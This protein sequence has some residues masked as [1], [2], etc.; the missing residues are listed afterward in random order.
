MQVCLVPQ[1]FHNAIYP[2]LFDNTNV[3]FMFRLMPYYFGAGCC[4]ITG[5]R[6]MRLLPMLLLVTLQRCID[7]QCRLLVVVGSDT[8][9]R[10]RSDHNVDWRAGT[11][12]MLRARACF[13]ACKFGE[14]PRCRRE[15]AAAESAKR[16]RQLFSE[17][18]VAEDVDLGSRIHA[19]GYKAI[20]LDEV[21]ARGEV[22]AR[23]TLASLHH[24][25]L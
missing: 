8:S 18:L 16:S 6:R 7:G 9:T 3:N 21:L 12:V 5:T 2:D 22:R 20:F 23:V 1:A 25:L 4:L 11:N 14:Q 19:L 24:A 15:A 13:L 17:V 10:R